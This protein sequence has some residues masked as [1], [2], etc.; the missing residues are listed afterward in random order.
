MSQYGGDKMSNGRL[1]LILFGVGAITVFLALWM[2]LKAPV[3]PGTQLQIAQI[4][5]ETPQ[6]LKYQAGFQ[7]PKIVEKSEVLLNLEAI[8]T[9]DQGLVSLHFKSGHVL[10]VRPSTLLSVELIERTNPQNKKPVLAININ[11]HRGDL[12]VVKSGDPQQLFITKNKTQIDAESF[13]TSEL[14]QTPTEW[15]LTAQRLND[16]QNADGNLTESEIFL[17]V[18]SFKTLFLKCFAPIVERTRGEAYGVASLRFVIDKSG[19]PSSFSLNYK[20]IPMADK[21]FERCILDVGSRMKFRAFEKGEPVYA[22]V[23]LEFK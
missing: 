17:V 1:V 18:D 8:E 12:R 14:M 22:E 2:T 20:Q 3:N 19:I 7:K 15:T 23:P 11:L 6:V 10:Q 4:Q 16:A 21:D 5:V 9:S 13:L